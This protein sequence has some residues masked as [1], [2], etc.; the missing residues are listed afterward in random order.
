M[1]ANGAIKS[2]RPKL[3]THSS[4]HIQEALQ[5][6]LTEAQLAEIDR[7]QQQREKALKLFDPVRSKDDSSVSHRRNPFD[8]LTHDPR[9]SKEIF[10]IQLHPDTPYDSPQSQ[11]LYS[12]LY[13]D[14]PTIAMIAGEQ[15]QDL[16]LD[17]VEF[18][19]QFKESMLNEYHK[20]STD[21]ASLKLSSAH[22]GVLGPYGGSRLCSWA[23]LNIWQR[24]RKR[25]H[26]SQDASALQELPQSLSELIDM[27]SS[28]STYPPHG[29]RASQKRRLRRIKR[30][31]DY[32]K[33]R[34]G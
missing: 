4:T 22:L 21:S 14:G 33:T 25:R 18:V 30:V 32:Y 9:F 2:M 15:Y 12:F 24:N 31:R 23:E 6:S 1:G 10:S 34:S 11:S 3:P 17:S 19:A 8:D 20:T 27:G 7:W 28:E 5:D 26:P 29:A 13:N 16:N